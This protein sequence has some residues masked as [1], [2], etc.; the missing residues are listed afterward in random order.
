M[1]AACVD[2]CGFD[3]RMR[4]ECSSNV[5]YLRDHLNRRRYRRS[6]G[7]VVLFLQRVQT[8]STSRSCPLVDGSLSW[9]LIHLHTAQ[10][11][12]VPGGELIVIENRSGCIQWVNKQLIVNVL[13]VH[14]LTDALYT[15]QQF[16]YQPTSLTKRVGN[17]RSNSSCLKDQVNLPSPEWNWHE[18]AAESN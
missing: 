4:T 12:L 18:S 5:Q 8:M 16:V 1:V 13:T 17:D 7:I 9:L 3:W 6:W 2:N 14:F 10:P 15:L 11:K